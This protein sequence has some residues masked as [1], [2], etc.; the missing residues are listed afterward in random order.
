M[1][2]LLM[3]NIIRHEW[4]IINYIFFF[5]KIKFILKIQLMIIEVY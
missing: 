4:R 5:E 1:K 2:L 3:K